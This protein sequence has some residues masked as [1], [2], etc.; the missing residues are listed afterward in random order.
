MAPDNLFNDG[1]TYESVLESLLDSE[2]E[3]DR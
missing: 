1:K 2:N 3:D